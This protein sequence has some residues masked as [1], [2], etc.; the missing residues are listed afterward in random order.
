MFLD[1]SAL[2]KAYLDEEGSSSMRGVLEG[3]RHMLFV[4]DFVVLEV[5]TS[6]RNS[7]RSAATVDFTHAVDRFEADHL[8][9]SKVDVAPEIQKAAIEMTTPFR[10]ARARS[11]D[12]LHVATALWLQR[13][14]CL[15]GQVMTIVTSDHDL[16]ALARDCGLRTFD[17]SREPLAALPRV[18]R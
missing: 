10:S 8:R 16:S 5:L 12:V 11:M 1:S 13:N 3:R 17:P 14:V 2:A 6:I 4:S 7:L 15:P 18:R 9:L